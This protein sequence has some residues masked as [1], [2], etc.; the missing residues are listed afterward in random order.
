MPNIA[1]APFV[2]RGAVVAALLTVAGACSTDD[3]TA[4]LPPVE[5]TMT[6]DASAGWVYVDLDEGE[7]VTPTPSAAESEAWDMA[8]SVTNVMLNGGEA[9]PGG[10]VGYCVCQNAGATN[11]EVVAM[12]AESELADFEGVTAVAPGAAWI[13][14]V[15]T[16]AFTGWYTGSGAAAAADPSRAFLTR[17]SGGSAY[18]KI[19]VVDL[20]NPTATTPGTITFE[21]AIQ[22]TSAEP[23]GETLTHVTTVHETGT[24]L[25]DL[26]PQDGVPI[27]EGWDLKVEGWDVILNGGPSGPAQVGVIVTD[28]PFEEI[29]TA[30]IEGVAYRTDSFTG[31][32]GPHRWYR[33]NLEGNNRIHP[34]FEVYLL[35]RGE[36]VY[37]IQ[38]LDYYGD[39]GAPRQIT[40]RYERIAP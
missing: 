23:F 19:R 15:L 29:T 35:K 39:T 12:T 2:L 22:P 14:D 17:L 18:A 40:F 21:Y 8:F 33:Y 13:E 16:P 38:L 5:G 32:F 34:T 20:E 24:T 27:G 31:V 30:Y 10:V 28:D 37:K 4:P 7:T 1:T 9:G 3:V 11:A 26:D 36:S 6:V 25:I